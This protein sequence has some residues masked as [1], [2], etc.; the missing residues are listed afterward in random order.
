MTDHENGW[1]K[2]EVHVLAELARLSTAT[3][4]L[5]G[6]LFRFESRIAKLEVRAGIWGALGGAIPLAIALLVGW[7]R[8]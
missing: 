6:A 2:H 5:T 8:V 1:P 4:R 3:D 7:L